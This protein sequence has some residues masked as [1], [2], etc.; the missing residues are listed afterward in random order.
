ME[1]RLPTTPQVKGFGRA[2]VVVGGTE[3]VAGRVEAGLRGF[4]PKSSSSGG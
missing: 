2:P 1:C 3:E 4:F